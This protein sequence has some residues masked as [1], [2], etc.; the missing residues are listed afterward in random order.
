[1]IKSRR[2]LSEIFATLMLLGVTTAGSVML[3]GLIQGVGIGGQTENPQAKNFPA[4]AIKLTGYDTRDANDLL[5]IATLDNKFDQK[6]CTVGCSTT[7]NNIPQNSGTE[8]AVL[9]IKNTSHAT[10]YLEGIQINNVLHTWDIDTGGKT[11]DASVN[12]FTGKYPQ[13]GKFSILSMSGL[14]QQSDNTLV[15]DQ[16]VRLVVKLGAGMNADLSIAKPMLVQVDFGGTK[17]SDSVIL[18]GEIR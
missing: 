14:V 9:Q 16:E 11:L 10:V 3:A 13:N 18:S 1:M 12:D 6:V 4:Y 17:T 5:G 15:E 8:F 7:P 2:G